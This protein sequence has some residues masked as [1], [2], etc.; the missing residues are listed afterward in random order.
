[1]REIG[2]FV[3]IDADDNHPQMLLVGD[4]NITGGV[5]LPNGILEITSNS[6]VGWSAEMHKNLGNI[7]FTD[8]H[9]ETL[10][11]AFLREC[12]TNTGV[13]TNRLAIP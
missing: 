2:Y 6:V 7:A 1:M 13:A 4:R 9:V 12:L 10:T 5:R 8:G 11:T 3:G